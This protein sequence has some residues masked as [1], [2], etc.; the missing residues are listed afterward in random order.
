MHY[1]CCTVFKRSYGYCMSLCILHCIL[2]AIHWWIK[3]N[4]NA[5]GKE[6]ENKIM[7]RS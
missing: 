3:M 5:V 7:Q 2:S 6:D 1:N 4:I